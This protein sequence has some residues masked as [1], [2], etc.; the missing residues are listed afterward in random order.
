M[1]TQTHE[2]IKEMK[3]SNGFFHSFLNL[4]LLGGFI[5][6]AIFCGKQGHVGLTVTISIVGFFVWLIHLCGLCLI[7]PNQSA[8]LVFFGKYSGTIKQN[9]FFWVNP[10]YSRKKLWLRARNLNPEVIKVNDKN[11]NPIMIGMMLVWKINDTFKA[12][13]CIDSEKSTNPTTGMLSQDLKSF[14]RFVHV[15]S[16]AALRKV[17]RMYAYD[18]IDSKSEEITLRSGDDE[19]NA[20]L[21]QELSERLAIAGI[22]VV[23][24]RINNLAYAPEIASVM[25]RR[26]QAEAI[27]A[28]REKIV[29][30]A[31]SMVELALKRLE[32]DGVV[33]LDSDKKATMA[34]HL[35]VV[36]CAD[37]NVKPV[38]NAGS[39]Y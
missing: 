24:A 29:E 2:F 11:G 25:L 3:R 1:K 37:E 19:I 26:Q 38:I 36:L 23:E 4:L 9:G 32:K 35:M 30:G 5:F 12:S 39:L 31:V 10:F 22:E 33:E 17:A 8:V 16:D 27:I 15:Q 13:F 7:Q 28:A 14:D 18:H 34:S 20:H 21:E 6:L